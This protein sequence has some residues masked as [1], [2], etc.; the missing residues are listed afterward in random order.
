MNAV[1]A[2]AVLGAMPHAAEIGKPAPAFT[3]ADSNGKNVA[4]STFKGKLV[5]LEW[6][7][8]ECPYVVAHYQGNMQALQKKYTAQGV[9]WLS[10]VS[11][12]PGAQGHLDGPK[13][14]ALTKERGA[15]PTHVLLDPNCELGR[16]YN[17]V[18]TPH[19]FVIDKEGVLRYDGAIDSSRTSRASDHRPE[20]SYV[21]KAL[22]ALIAGRPVEIS[23]T[24]A[25][26]CTIK[27]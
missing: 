1:L 26:G 24:Q 10:V 22:D 2:L 25:Y 14:N 7:N 5:V 27:Y 16:I 11:C 6:T 12:K 13:A 23:K 4:L 15:A 8:H 3:V 18:T 9:V 21:G 20:D 17:A 19:M